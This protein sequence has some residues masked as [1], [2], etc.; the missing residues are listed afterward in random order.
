MVEASFRLKHKGMSLAFRMIDVGGQR[1]ERRKWIHCF[2]NVDAILFVVA[3]SEYNQVL[4][5]DG[6]TNRM[7]ESLK[8]FESIVNNAFFVRTSFILF[9]NKVDLFDKK[10]SVFP[11]E[12]YQPSFKDSNSFPR[13]FIASMYLG[14]VRRAAED[15]K[16]KKGE[17]SSSNNKTL[18]HHFT[19][20][21]DTGQIKVIFQDVIE[22]I[23]QRTLRESHLL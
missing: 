1:S 2:E 19:C 11:L 20:A 15:K 10:L 16:K 5:E 18:F 9:L 13:E 8:L 21:T 6:R 7:D 12:K 3:I 17:E 4:V 14:K 23:I 22:I